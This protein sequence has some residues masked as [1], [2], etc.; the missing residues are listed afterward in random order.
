MSLT[1]FDGFIGSM[2]HLRVGYL[3]STAL[4]AGTV[5][6]SFVSYW[7]TVGLPGAGS[8]NPGNIT[9]GVVPTDSTAGALTLPVIAAGQTMYLSQ[10]HCNTPSSSANNVS[11]FVL[12]DRLWH[13][14]QF[15][16]SSLGTT[17]LTP[18]ALTRPNSTGLQTEV[19]LECAV[20]GSAS[21]TTVSLSYTNSSGTSGRTASGLEDITTLTSDKVGNIHRFVLAAG[22]YGVQSI[23]SITFG[24]ATNAAGK[25]N[26]IILRRVATLLA[27]P[28]VSFGCIGMLDAFHVGLPQVYANACLAWMGPSSS[29]SNV[30]GGLIGD[31][32]FVLSGTG[33]PTTVVVSPATFTIV[34]GGTQQLY[35]TVL[36]QN[37]LPM[38]GQT[39]SWSSS[40][41]GVATVNSSTGL[42]TGV[43]VGSA[44]ITATSGSLTNTSSGTINSALPAG[45]ASLVSSLG[46]D[47]HVSEFLDFRGS[48]T[49]SG[50]NITAAGDIRGAGFGFSLSPT[51]S[52]T[53]SSN[54]AVFA[55]GQD[56]H[57]AAQ[58]AFALTSA[59]SVLIGAKITAGNSNSVGIAPSGTATAAI[60]VGGSGT[61][62]GVFT[63]TAV[64]TAVAISSTVVP[65]VVTWDGFEG[66]TIQ[67]PNQSIVSFTDADP[68]DSGNGVL[69][70]GGFFTNSGLN[71]GC[72]IACVLVVDH[73]VN[74]TEVNAFRDYVVNQHGGVAQ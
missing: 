1:T 21:A 34:T 33:T 25:W 29:A 37:G 61:V 70:L 72:E 47:S 50:S 15:S 53:L 68:Y 51:G 67:I 27:C 3:K 22:D 57:T 18:T 9:T 45:D 62:I 28:F 35:A 64:N 4:A 48:A 44:T 41:T 71:G 8:N 16:A 74:S 56:L 20:A 66:V 19:W 13:A 63:N 14:G 31:L 49:T 17:T 6:G 5:Q 12:Y 11:G 60:D 23:Q 36:D 59:G 26:L 42:V 7:S 52:P 24:G 30:P 43:A 54:R 10:A 58:A 46:G 69:C 38:S 55:S 39:V 2:P 32:G 73:Q 40:N 65:I